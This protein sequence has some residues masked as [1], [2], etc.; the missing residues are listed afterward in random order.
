MDADPPS[1]IRLTDTQLGILAA[2]CRPIAAGNSY[3]TPATNQEIA[4]EVFLSVDAVKGHLR[5]LYRKFGIEDLPHNQKRARLVELA[6]EGGYVE[7]AAAESETAPRPADV[8]LGSVE[9]IRE[10]E[11][12]A[13]AARPKSEKRS[14]GP[15][16][17]MAT[18]IL[19]VIGATLSVSGIFNQGPTATKAPSPAAFR[20][21]V[22]GY[23]KLAMAGAP[24]TEGQGRAERARGYLEVI[25]TMRGRLQSLVQPTLPNIALERFSTGLTTAANYTSDVAQRLP[26]PGSELEAKYVAELTFAAGQVQ[27]GAVGYKL[28]HD[29]LAIGDLVAGSAENA[30]AP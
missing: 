8:P 30:A 10:A 18:L 23:C 17:T 1:D 21:E 26:A 2:L 16:V 3:A 19:V 27:A 25:E 14:I 6:I 4:A 20:T 29:C 28:G 13:A 22:A 7:S 11:R 24:S 9:A 5:T 12:A 15:Y